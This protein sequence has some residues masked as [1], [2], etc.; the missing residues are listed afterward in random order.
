MRDPDE[1]QIVVYVYQIQPPPPWWLYAVTIAA[2]ATV[3]M[4]ALMAFIL[5]LISRGALPLPQAFA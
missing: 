3:L 5:I 1:R 4:V 2:I